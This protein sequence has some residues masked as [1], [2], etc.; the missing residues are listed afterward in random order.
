MLLRFEQQPESQ[1]RY[2]GLF[3]SLWKWEYYEN[4]SGFSN[5]GF[6]NRY[7]TRPHIPWPI[8]RR[9]LHLGQEDYANTSR[10]CTN[11]RQT[12]RPVETIK[13]TAA[14]VVKT[15][16]RG[17]CDTYSN[18]TTNIPWESES[19][20]IV[21]T[22]SIDPMTIESMQTGKMTKIGLSARGLYEVWENAS[23]PILATN[24]SKRPVTLTEI[25]FIAAGLE[26]LETINAC[27][28]LAPLPTQN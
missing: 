9:D 24:F 21:I 16:R 4:A 5:R 28:Q 20:V 12:R 26:P 15:W 8:H 27:D 22:S 1:S 18:N 13:H 6:S 23:L 11:S 14:Q 19:P 25:L 3:L 7:C 17:T 10:T 2:K